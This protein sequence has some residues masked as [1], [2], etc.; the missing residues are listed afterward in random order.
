MD[1]NPTKLTDITFHLIVESSPS[2]VLLANNDG[3]IAYVNRQCEVLF[4][5]N[6]AELIGQQVETLIPERFR[7][8]HPSLRSDYSK[9]PTLRSMGVGRELYGLRKD[10]TEFPVEIGLNPLVLVDGIWVLATVVDITE[11]KRSEDRFR[12]VV[13]SAP[14]AMLLVDRKGRIMLANQQAGTLFGYS[15]KELCGAQ[16]EIL[17]PEQ[18]RKHHD[19]LRDGF[20]DHPQTRYMGSGRDLIGLRKDGTTMPIEVGLNPVQTND[21][22][23]VLVS[24]VDISERKAQEE[25]RAKKEAAEAAYKAKGELLAIASHDLKNPLSSIAG[26]A[27]ILL[28]MKTAEGGASQ[29]DIEFLK[30]IHEAS[31]HMFEVVKGILANEGLEQEGLSITKDDVDLSALATDLVQFATPSAERKGITLSAVITPDI[32]YQG[33]K[34]RLREALDNYISNA[35]KYSPQGKTVTVSLTLAA[36]GKWIEFGVRDQGPGIT[37]EDK[38]QLFGKFK[39]LSARPTAGESSTGLGLSIVKAIVE[40]HGGQVGCDSTP[41]QGAYFWARLPLGATNAPL[42]A[43]A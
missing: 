30:S 28:D 9:A 39:K 40:L 33:D 34:T 24:V 3:R 38:P 17:I 32:H 26:L 12:Q 36:D 20:F 13:H 43:A 6:A 18:F 21:D 41:G 11:R 19:S 2:A 1:T 14:N 4:G 25:L 42:T 31:S 35:V 15:E 22:L 37:E 10:G 16:V 23:M 5:Y 7:D 8:K 29:Q 27:Q